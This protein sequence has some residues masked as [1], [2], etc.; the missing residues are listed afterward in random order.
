MDAMIEGILFS[1]YGVT[2]GVL[3][4]AAL[5][6]RAAF[7][8]F[9]RTELLTDASVVEDMPSVTVCIPA[10]NEGHAMT[11][12][13]QRII[14]SHYPKLEIIVLDDLSGDKTSSLIKAFA[15]DGVRFVEG[16]PLPQGWLGKNHALNELL[17]EA[18]GTYVLYLAVDTRIEPD[19]I[20]QLVTYATHENASMVSVLP[21]REDGIRFST[22]FSPLR[23]FW[24]LIFHHR[25]APAVSSGAW[26]IHRQ[27]FIDTHGD[28]TPFKDAIQPEAKIAAR[29]M[30]GGK[31]R[32]LIG[33]PLL[34]VS[35]E[36]R[37]TSQIE[38]SVRLAYP[39]LGAKLSHVIVSIL[40]LLIVVSPYLV[41]LIALFTGPT[42]LHVGALLI[43]VGYN[44]LYGVYL[45]RVWR[46]GW[47][48]GALLWPFIVIQEAWIIA[49]STYRYARGRVTWKGRVVHLP[50]PS[51]LSK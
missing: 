16:S 26:M 45:R 37:W 46:R 30:D 15:H 10:R 40:D 2:A 50:R 5:R 12:C 39:M 8:R 14:A 47:W 32:F 29:A 20:E 28:F 7:K 49:L 3:G 48:I 38:T 43:A 6:L 19:T 21:R 4:V 44:I 51:Q 34:G 42:V 33:T 36:K 1:L 24:E 13:L 23:Y 31:Y 18:S 35:Y 11:D 25:A 17:K 27:R 41:L 9:T 22:I